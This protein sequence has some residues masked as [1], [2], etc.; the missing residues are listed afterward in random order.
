[1][2]GEM[3]E[4]GEC[5]QILAMKDLR[6]AWTRIMK[7]APFDDKDRS[8]REEEDDGRSAP[9]E[10]DRLKTHSAPPRAGPGSD[11]TSPEMIF[12]FPNS[13]GSL[14]KFP[15]NYRPCLT[16]LGHKMHTNVTQILPQTG[17]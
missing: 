13:M 10:F 2:P 6:A 1:M 7:L 11:T 9:A 8:T 4:A 15:F 3:T 12:Y 17:I 16:H 14:L 5:R